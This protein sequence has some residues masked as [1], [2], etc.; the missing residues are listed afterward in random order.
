VPE[1]PEVQTIVSDLTPTLPGLTV[2]S[3]KYVGSLGRELLYR[4]RVDLSLSLQGK[5]ITGVR[6]L[7]KQILLDLDSG[8]SLSFHLKITGR[9]LL[10][11]AN[12]PEDEFSRL[13]MFFDN[14]QELRLTDRNGLATADLLTQSELDAQ[15]GR[16]GPEILN[17]DLTT[18]KF[19]EL[20]TSSTEPSL[21]ETLLNQ[22][23]VSGMGNIYVDEAL[24]LA[25][26]HPNLKPKQISEEQSALLLAACREVLEA[27][28]RDRGTT[29]DSY[30]DAF[31]RPGRHQDNLRVYGREGKS[32]SVCGGTIEYKEVGGR[33]TFYCPHCQSL[34]QLDLFGGI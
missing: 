30:L 2:T 1:L 28:L 32:C 10:R 21:K 17:P 5:K 7:A 11:E 9:L 14:G 33:R 8:E 20:V 27:G 31:G 26:L 12:D 24:F 34:P 15:K 29:I 25:K 18:T 23:I 3:A 4:S 22:K 6:R 19:F 16:Y 13:I